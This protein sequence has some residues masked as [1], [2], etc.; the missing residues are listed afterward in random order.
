ME[1]GGGSNSSNAPRLRRAT[2][3]GGTAPFVVERDKHLPP[4]GAGCLTDSTAWE[5][6]RG[7]RSPTVGLTLPA[8]TEEDGE[9]EPTEER[10]TRET[11]RR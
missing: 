4:P 2:V 11:V 7:R 5:L 9:Q 8:Y 6:R 1:R 3:K 10:Q